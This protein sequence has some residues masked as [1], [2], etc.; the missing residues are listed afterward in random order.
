MRALPNRVAPAAEG[1]D[2]AQGEGTSEYCLE[3]KVK[4][5]NALNSSPFLVL[6]VTMILL[7][8]LA[9]AHCTPKAQ[10][11]QIESAIFKTISVCSFVLFLLETI[12]CVFV[13]GFARGKEAY[14]R[15]DYLNVLNLI[16]LV[17]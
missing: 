2:E 14:L 15:R 4:L 8:C 1:G 10:P 7:V 6:K 17:V 16:L 13:H 5:L 12:A 9:L 3:L 11:T